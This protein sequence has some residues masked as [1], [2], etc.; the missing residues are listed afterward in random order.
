MLRVAKRDA[1]PRT[2]LLQRLVYGDE[3]VDAHLE[4]ITMPSLVVWG[5]HDPL[6]PVTLGERIAAA[7]PGAE[8][9][10]FENTA[11]SHNV[12]EPERFNA[13]LL[14]FLRR[15]VTLNER[16]TPVAALG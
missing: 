5:R 11:H 16:D 8:M 2:A 3:H 6:T 10:L 14:D 9:A 13:L 1:V 15:G 12:E 4:R 7:I